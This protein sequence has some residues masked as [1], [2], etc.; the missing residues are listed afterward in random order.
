MTNRNPIKH[1]NIKIA[2]KSKN[3]IDSEVR[4]Y[5]ASPQTN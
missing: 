5:F 1:I 4:K 3:I 2:S